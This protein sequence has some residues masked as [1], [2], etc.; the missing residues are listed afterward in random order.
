MGG[1]IVNFTFPKTFWPHFV[2]F[3]NHGPTAHGVIRWNGEEMVIQ[4]F[5]PFMSRIVRMHADQTNFTKVL[6]KALTGRG[7]CALVYCEA[8]TQ[9]WDVNIR[10]VFEVCK[11]CLSVFLCQTAAGGTLAGGKRGEESSVGWKPS[12]WS[13]LLIFRLVML[14]ARIMLHRLSGFFMLRIN[15]VML[16]FSRVREDCIDTFPRE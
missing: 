9:T 8:H 16:W 13:H 7:Q 3:M 2:P 6:K 10:K 4:K 5:F 11:K 14:C 1:K 15:L 12:I